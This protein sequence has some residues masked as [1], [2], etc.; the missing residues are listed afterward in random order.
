MNNLIWLWSDNFTSLLYRPT[1][2][3]KCEWTQTVIEGPKICLWAPIEI[4]LDIADFKISFYYTQLMLLWLC[5]LYFFFFFCRFKLE[6]TLEAFETAKT[7]A[8]GA[9]K[10]MIKC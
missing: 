6:E 2:V 7:G 3:E 8:G 9:I 4:R 1:C 10:V 5:I